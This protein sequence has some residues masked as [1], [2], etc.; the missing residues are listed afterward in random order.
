MRASGMRFGGGTGLAGTLTSA[1]GT[2]YPGVKKV[3]CMALR[4]APAQPFPPW[5]APS[6]PAKLHHPAAYRA[7]SGT[8]VLETLSRAGVVRT[9]CPD[10]AP[11][12]K[13]LR[14]SAR[15]RE[16]VGAKNAELAFDLEAGETP[17]PIGSVVPTGKIA[18]RF[19]RGTGTSQSAAVVSGLAAL[20]FSQFPDATSD[21]IKALLRSTSA[22]QSPNSPPSRSSSSSSHTARSRR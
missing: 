17:V 10:S 12:G 13:V 22:T 3:S 2:G 18:P 6:A 16:S 19:Q 14:Y 4:I 20:L 9:G 21:Q 7:G 1:A 11:G 8:H 15:I 5:V